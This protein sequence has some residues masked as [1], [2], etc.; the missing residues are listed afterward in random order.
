MDEEYYGQLKLT[1][2]T[3]GWK[4]FIADMTGARRDIEK[5]LLNCP[6]WDTY[7]LNK[8]QL[9]TLDNILRFEESLKAMEAYAEQTLEEDEDF[10]L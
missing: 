4:I 5:K 9:K 2:Q 6:D 10:D 3:N 1:F 8:G 7:L